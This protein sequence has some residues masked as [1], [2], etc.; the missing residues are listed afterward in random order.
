MTERGANLKLLHIFTIHANHLM[1][2]II[3]ATFLALA[4]ASAALGADEWPARSVTLVVG[5]T[6]GGNTDMAARILAASIE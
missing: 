5:Y 6:A 1:R 2:K 4:C 3:V